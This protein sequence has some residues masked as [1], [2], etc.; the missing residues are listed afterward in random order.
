[1]SEQDPL[2][3]D[4]FESQA[5][6]L[7]QALREAR[8]KAKLVEP[9]LLARW[10]TVPLIAAILGIAFWLLVSKGARDGV[11]QRL[12]K[13]DVVGQVATITI[14]GL[15][16][17]AG[18]PHGIIGDQVREAEEALPSRRVLE[19][20]RPQRTPRRLPTAQEEKPIQE[21]G[22]IAEPSRRGAE[23]APTVLA[24]L[25]APSGP[26]PEISQ[27]AYNLILSSHSTM[28][29]LVSQGSSRWSVVKEDNGVIWIDIVIVRDGEEHYIW[30]VNLQKQAVRPLSQAARNLES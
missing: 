12:V 22:T 14:R 29:Q 30:A 9:G 7:R 21:G 4:R 3:K 25:V 17:K 28:R 11:V 20:Q 24:P 5:E 18:A 15:S 23:S 16:E 13:E 19:L 10:S 6:L 1:M 8:D 2:N 26:S 27:A